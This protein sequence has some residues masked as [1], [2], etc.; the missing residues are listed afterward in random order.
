MKR[1]E[2]QVTDD[3]GQLRPLRIAFDAQGHPL[4][5]TH[6]L[7]PLQP[8]AQI[9]EATY[10]SFAPRLSGVFSQ[11]DLSG[12]AG[13][14][15]QVSINSADYNRYYFTEWMDWTIQGQG[16]KGPAVGV[17]TAP[18]S[19][20]TLTGYFELAGKPYLVGTGKIAYYS[21]GSLF[22]ARDFSS[23]IQGKAAVFQQLSTEA[24]VATSTGDTATDTITNADSFI[25]QQIRIT[26]S[27]VRYWR[28]HRY[29]RG[30]CHQ[31]RGRDSRQRC[32]YR[33]HG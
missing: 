14:K 27:G 33:H 22:Q 13:K 23:Y 1:Y 9:G 25:A 24:S 21:G 19:M 8:T 4:W 3:R 29:L 15:V 20:G 7:D 30:G 17:A 31:R 32:R 6:I 5:K 11:G 16:Q 28:N 12:G 2:V 26:S 10:A 18:A